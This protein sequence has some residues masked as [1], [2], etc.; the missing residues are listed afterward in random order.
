MFLCTA[1]VASLIYSCA[2]Y[3]SVKTVVLT[4]LS[5]TV[6]VPFRDQE[7]RHE[8][9]D[10]RPALQPNPRYK[11]CPVCSL[12]AWNGEPYSEKF[13]RYVIMS[14][15]NRCNGSVSLDENFLLTI[16]GLL[17]QGVVLLCLF[18]LLLRICSTPAYSLSF[19]RVSACNACATRYWFG[20]SVRPSVRPS[21][22]LSSAGTVSKQMDISS[23]LF[24]GPGWGI[25]LVFEPRRRYKIPR[26]T[27]SA[28]ALNTRRVGKFCKYRQLLLFGTTMNPGRFSHRGLNAW[29]RCSGDRENVLAWD[30]GVTTAEKLRGTKV[31]VQT[32]GRLRPAPGQRPG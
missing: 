16:I 22:C 25:I 14:T 2:T 26:G 3:S 24:D 18:I 6:F 31:W 1:K 11:R 32:P 10:I 9:E 5:F 28:G 8:V 29:G 19:Y 4:F 21:V 23:P 30:R 12:L 17:L 7:E 27:P 20:N 15:W 13:P